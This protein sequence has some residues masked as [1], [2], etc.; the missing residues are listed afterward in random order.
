MARPEPAVALPAASALEPIEDPW[1]Q[2]PGTVPTQTPGADP[3]TQK[4]GLPAT[5]API[6]TEEHAWQQTLVMVRQRS[7][8]VWVER[9]LNRPY[10]AG[11]AVDLLRTT[12]AVVP[13]R[14]PYLVTL[15]AAEVKLA[16]AAKILQAL[17]D[18]M[19]T[20]LLEAHTTV[21]SR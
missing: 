21:T 16:A 1:I 6:S 11:G 10:G 3:L 7:V 18:L 8:L 14:P 17:H 9:V 4:L 5:D 12:H 20:T 15:D 13:E 2:A 19:P